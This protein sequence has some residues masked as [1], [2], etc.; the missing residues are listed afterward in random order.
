M[1][2]VQKLMQLK[3]L[4][5]K[6]NG[7]LSLAFTGRVMIDIEPGEREIR[8][9][10]TLTEFA[11]VVDNDDTGKLDWEYW[12]D[13]AIEVLCS[14]RI[15]INGEM[16]TVKQALLRVANTESAGVEM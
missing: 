9:L 10:V 16:Y 6:C 14:P 11:H 12:S 3:E 5:D 4:A 15:M 2:S 13:K 1:I 7:H 8:H